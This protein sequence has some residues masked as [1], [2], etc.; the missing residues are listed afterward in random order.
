M[1]DNIILYPIINQLFFATVMLFLWRYSRWQK[2]ISIIG[3]LVGFGIAVVMMVSIWNDGI[4][5]YHTGNWMAPI[6][7][8]FV[9]DMLAATLVLLT[10]ICGMAVSMYSAGSM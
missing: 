3:N 7:I 9:G 6:G 4:L 1:T 5:T 2:S 8:T 10:S